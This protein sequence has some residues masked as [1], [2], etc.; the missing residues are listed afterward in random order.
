MYT[1]IHRNDTLK[2]KSVDEGTSELFR[3][4][5]TSRNYGEM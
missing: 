2:L 4:V 5:W 3:T 1:H